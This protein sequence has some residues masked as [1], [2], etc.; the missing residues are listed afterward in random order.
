MV[1]RAPRQRKAPCAV[2]RALNARHA[3]RSTMARAAE[4]ARVGFHPRWTV[5]AL[6]WP[7]RRCTAPARHHV[8][9]RLS[10]RTRR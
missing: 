8:G 7:H 9:T 6:T 3:A 5:V 10:R 4:A 2:L 1:S